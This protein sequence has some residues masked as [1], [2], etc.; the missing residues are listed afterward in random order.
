MDLRLGG[1]VEVSRTALKRALAH[2]CG[3]QTKAAERLGLQRTFLNRRMRDLGLRGATPP[4][5]G[6]ASEPTPPGLD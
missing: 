5:S 2:T 6:E 1:P 4:G 3:N